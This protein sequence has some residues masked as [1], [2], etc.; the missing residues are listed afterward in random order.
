ME[1]YN[2]IKTDNTPLIKLDNTKHV[3]EF[4][5]DSR[6]ENVQKFF[7]PIMEWLDN[8]DKYIYYLKDVNENQLFD[9]NCNFKLEYFNSSS[10]KYIMDILI[11]LGKI[12]K[13]H[14]VKLNVNWYYDSIDED[15]LD[16]GKEFEKVVG[17]S[18]NYI[19]IV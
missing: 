7:L 11:F 19:E 4:E 6:P 9:I 17:I 8:Y 10:A 18:F 5:G 12:S 13:T 16:A 1:I 14:Q 2:N 15:M 3:L